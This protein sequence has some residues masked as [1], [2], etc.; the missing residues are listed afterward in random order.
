MSATDPSL[1]LLTDLYQLTM[2]QAAWKA[3]LW[4]SEAAFHLFFRK[5]PFKGG[6]TV[7][8]GLESALEYL[9]A[10]KFS[11]G[12]ISYLAS[13]NDS[14]GAQLFDPGFLTALGALELSV[15]VDAIPEGTVV[16]PQ[17]PLLRVIGPVAQCMLLETPLLNLINFQTLIATKAARICGAAKGEPVIEFGLRRAQGID[18][19][20]SASRAAYLGGVTATS[21]VLAGKRYGIPVRGTHAHSWVML[22]DDELAAFQAYADALPGNVIF[23]VDTYDTLE[24][25]RH[26]I[27]VGRKLRQAGHELLGVR[28]DSGDLAWLSIEARKLLDAAGFEKTSILASN[29]LDEH[30]IQS[31]KEQGATINSWG[32]GTRLVTGDSEPALGGVYKLS[33]VRAAGGPW[34]PRLK[35]SEQTAKVST[36]GILNVRR[37]TETTDNGERLVA[38]LIWDQERGLAPE[39]SAQELIDPNDAT[40]RKRV[41][42]GTRHQELLVPV[43]RGGKQVYAPPPL[44]E[45]RARTFA[46]LARLDFTH[47]RLHNP[48]AYPVGL[49]PALHA[50]RTELILTHR[51]G[52]AAHG[53]KP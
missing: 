49:E 50:F 15:D 13:L 31:L 32:I 7:A 48:H 11:P 16:F 20:L 28:L 2:S 52:V 43:V 34:K 17:E 42:A 39:G 36:P 9:R 3:G 14:R 41:P 6:Y 40:R 47:K 5:A 1:A 23:L 51:T 53:S 22:F 18:G 12:D 33:A 38:D 21:N 8:A 25:V 26:A 29:D 27:E 19:A 44:A 46:E 24:G 4:D 37:F 45:S 30:L 35:L 10:F